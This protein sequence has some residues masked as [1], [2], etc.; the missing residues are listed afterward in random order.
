MRVDIVQ[1]RPEKLD[2]YIELQLEDVNPVLRRAGVPFRST[3][4]T[5]EFGNTYERVFVTPIASRGEFDTA[6]P[7]ARAMNPDRAARLLDRA[8]LCLI[9]R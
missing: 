4:R 8:R 3:W 6:G 1:I 9:G 2:D 5:A 7:L